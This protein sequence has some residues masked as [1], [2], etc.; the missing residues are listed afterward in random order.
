MYIP[1]DIASP[2][3]TPFV[4]GDRNHRD[5]RPRLMHNKIGLAQ[6]DVAAHTFIHPIMCMRTP[7]LNNIVIQVY[8]NQ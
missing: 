3:C 2:A 8:Q 5:S 4:L 1:N 6:A 7:D